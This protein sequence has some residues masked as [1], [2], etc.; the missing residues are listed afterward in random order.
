[1][2]IPHPTVDRRESI[3]IL[4]RLFVVVFVITVATMSVSRELLIPL[5]STSAVDGDMAGDPQYYRSLA[6]KKAS[7]IRQG[8]L[9]QFELRPEGQGPAGIASLLFLVGESPYGVVGLNAALHAIS[10]VVMALILMRWFPRRV[11]V[12]A[13][14]P[15]AISPL[16]VAWFSQINKDSYV[17]AGVLLFTLGLLR[18]P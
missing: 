5:M 6:L 7:E 17:T 13:T 12:I 11:S 15:L 2:R 9:G 3:R 8:G 4:V 16:M 14:V 18:K 1:M 10:V